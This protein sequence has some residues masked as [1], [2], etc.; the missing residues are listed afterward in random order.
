MRGLPGLKSGT[1]FVEGPIGRYYPEGCVGRD[2]NQYSF[3][4]ELI[5]NSRD[6]FEPLHGRWRP[7]NGDEYYYVTTELGTDYRIWVENYT[8]QLLFVDGNVFRT[9]EEAKAT[10]EKAKASMLS[11]HKNN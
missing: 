3:P 9:E 1:V 8:D 10:A 5:E 2:Q 7:E 11:L 6:W 4:Q